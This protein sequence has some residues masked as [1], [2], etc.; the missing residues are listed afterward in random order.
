MK[1]FRNTKKCECGCQFD[2]N[3]IKLDNWDC[4]TGKI[5]DR[6]KNVKNFT[7]TAFQYIFELQCP[8]CLKR[9]SATI[10]K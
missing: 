1:K 3:Y 7:E 8:Y 6:T 5:E 9:H 10:D 4:W 2:W